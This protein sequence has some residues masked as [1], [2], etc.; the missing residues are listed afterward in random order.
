[1]MGD[2][3]E[4]IKQ[5]PIE[6]VPLETSEVEISFEKT[7]YDP[8]ALSGSPLDGGFDKAVPLTCSLHS[9]EGL[10]TKRIRGWYEE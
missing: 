2:L 10:Y 7:V 8:P 1:M 9:R 4:A 6:K 3:D 5:V